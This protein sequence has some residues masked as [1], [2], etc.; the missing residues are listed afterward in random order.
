M[1]CH[2]CFEPAE[3]PCPKCH[4]PLCEMHTVASPDRIRVCLICTADA[5]PYSQNWLNYREVE[6]QHNSVQFQRNKALLAGHSLANPE[7]EMVL[8][9]IIRSFFRIFVLIGISAPLAILCHEGRAL[10]RK[11]QS[12]SKSTSSAFTDHVFRGIGMTESV[13]IEEYLQKMIARAC[14][15]DIKEVQE[16]WEQQT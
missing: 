9:S 7:G 4:E 12:L 11:A 5:E 6:R 8:I 14:N 16:T 3:S 2:I 15:L 10:A 1:E 13:T